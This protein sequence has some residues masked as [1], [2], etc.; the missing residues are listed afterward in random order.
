MRLELKRVS[1]STESTIGVLFLDGEFQCYT[2]EDEERTEKVYGETRIPEGHYKIGI[3]DVGG[4][5]SRYFQKFPQSH[6]G[7]L[8]IE[9]VPNFKYILIHIGNDDDDTA[10]CILV[11]NKPNNNKRDKGFLGDSTSAY[12][13]LYKKV[14]TEAEKGCLTITITD[15]EDGYTT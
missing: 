6:K 15:L 5:H 13:D 11:G 9:D 14:I 12:L 3:R 4:F 10:G 2:L 1:K 8:E 7:M